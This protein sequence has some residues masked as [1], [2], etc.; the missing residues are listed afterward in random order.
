MIKA[1]E[2]SMVCRHARDESAAINR[3]VSNYI[4][5]NYSWDCLSNCN[6]TGLAISY[7]DRDAEWDHASQ[8]ND[9]DARH[10]NHSGCANY[11][12]W[13]HLGC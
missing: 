6:P 2:K 10:L 1:S 13:F 11:R 8:R 9:E 12:F 4:N 7:I 3:G 5:D